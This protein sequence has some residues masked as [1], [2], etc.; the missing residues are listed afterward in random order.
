MAGMADMIS[1]STA[2]AILQPQPPPWASEVR[3]GFSAKAASC[4][5]EPSL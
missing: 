2:G 4:M 1:V 5:R 3:R